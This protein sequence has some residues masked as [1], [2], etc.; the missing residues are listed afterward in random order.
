MKN[1]LKSGVYQHY[2]GSYYLVLGVARH[3]VTEEKL[4]VYVP[5]YAEKSGPRMTARP[6]DVFFEEIELNGKRSPRFKYVGTEI[7]N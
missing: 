2:K 5:L 4:V 7:S 1:D 6:I 3:D